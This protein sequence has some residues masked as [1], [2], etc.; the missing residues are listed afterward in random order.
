MMIGDINLRSGATLSVM[1]QDAG[2]NYSLSV[3]SP[4]VSAT[5][6]AAVAQVNAAQTNLGGV[7]SR[8]NMAAS[9]IQGQQLDNTASI[10]SIND[11]DVAQVSTQLASYNILV[12]SAA[13]M[14]A[15]SNLDPQ[16][17]LKLLKTG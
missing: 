10:S 14:L 4:G 1:Q 3:N 16:A 17:I 11:V 2:G 5:L 13:A 15:Q 8:L 9:T 12:Q 7:Q 6:D